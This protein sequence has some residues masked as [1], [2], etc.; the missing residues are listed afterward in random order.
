MYG[1]GAG[2]R[3]LMAFASLVVMVWVS[4]LGCNP[5]RSTARISAAET[6]LEQA[7][8][9]EAHIK[10]PY[11]YTTAAYFLH[12][13]KEEWG[14]SDFEAAYDYAAKARTAADNARTRAK[15]NPWKGSPVPAEK[16]QTI[17]LPGAPKAV[18][19]NRPEDEP[20]VGPDVA[21]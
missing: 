7:R 17:E 8:V 18:D 19:R 4:S 9:A 15:E 16:L 2:A 5:V 10:A 12:K 11:E 3:R 6:A 20:E 1:R 14:Y 21:P 13:A